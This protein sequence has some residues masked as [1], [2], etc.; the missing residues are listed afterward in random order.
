MKRIA[1]IAFL[2]VAFLIMVASVAAA[3]DK[4]VLVVPAQPGATI[5]RHGSGALVKTPGQPT[6]SVAP[7]GNG[8]IIKEPG[9]PAVTC[10]PF[11]ST[12]V[13]R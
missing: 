6:K 7:F 8:T 10:K 2:T 12:Q 11:G 4:P 5:Q 3:A 13:C 9:K 1:V